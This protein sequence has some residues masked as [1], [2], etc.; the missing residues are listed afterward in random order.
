MLYAPPFVYLPEEDANLDEGKL[1]RSGVDARIDAYDWL[2]SIVTA[3]VAC[4]L[5]FLFVARIVNVDGTSMVPTLH[6]R[7]K[8]VI[9]RIYFHPK[10]GDIV[11]LTKRSFSDIS[12]VKRIIAVAG[13]TVDIDFERGEVYVDGVKLNE[14]YIAE[15]TTRQLDLTFPLTVPEGCVFCMGDNRNRST[16][17]RSSRVGMIDTRCIL[18]RVLWRVWPFGDFGAVNKYA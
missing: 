5:I 3:I 14:P 9:S 1:E 10:Q 6:D 2:E 11:V 8:V 13:Q 17:S 4:I 12:I 18:G 16:D 15:L 7:D